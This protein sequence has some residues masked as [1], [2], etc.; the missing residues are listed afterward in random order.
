VASIPPNPNPSVPL[1]ALQQSFK[2]ILYDFV[3]PGLHR[4]QT[5]GLHE[6]YLPTG[7][8]NAQAFS[9][10]RFRGENKNFTA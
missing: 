3:C 2:A 7:N 10:L 9:S 4:N 6:D 1:R 5:R 8:S